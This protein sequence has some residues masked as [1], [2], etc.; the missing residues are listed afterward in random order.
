MASGLTD[1]IFIDEDVEYYTENTYILNIVF[2][3]GSVTSDTLKATPVSSSAYQ[4]PAYDDGSF[5]SILSLSTDEYSAEPPPM[6][7]VHPEV[8][9]VAFGSIIKVAIMKN[10]DLLHHMLFQNLHRKKTK[11][12]LHD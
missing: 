12:Y 11:L 5:E 2:P 1:G 3:N 7:V 6:F 10:P 4:V 8:P 9:T